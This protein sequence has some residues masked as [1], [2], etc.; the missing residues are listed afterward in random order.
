MTA[1]KATAMMVHTVV[2]WSGSMSIHLHL[3]PGVD[4]YKI[5]FQLLHV[6]WNLYGDPMHP[7]LVWCV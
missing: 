5:A 4:R 3:P 2:C 7:L 1:V 6:L